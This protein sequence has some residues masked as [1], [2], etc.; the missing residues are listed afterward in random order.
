MYTM[1]PPSF[2]G[3]S[4]NEEGRGLTIFAITLATFIFDIKGV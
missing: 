4:G 2:Q 3:N 1:H